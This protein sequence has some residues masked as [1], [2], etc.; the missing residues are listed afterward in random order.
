VTLSL[1]RLCTIFTT[2][3]RYIN[4]III[5]IIIIIIIMLLYVVFDAFSAF[6]LTVSKRYKKKPE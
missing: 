1:Q 4:S 2:S 6:S 3:W 5:I